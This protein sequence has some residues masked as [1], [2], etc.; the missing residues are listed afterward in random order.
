L[1][2]RDV[3]AVRAA[4]LRPIGGQGCRDREAK[5]QG[6]REEWSD[7][8]EGLL[9]AGLAG[10]CPPTG[11]SSLASEAAVTR[12]RR[13]NRSGNRS[14]EAVDSVMP[15]LLSSPPPPPDPTAK[16]S[17]RE[18]PRR[19]RRRGLC[20]GTVRLASPGKRSSGAPQPPPLALC[21]GADA[22]RLAAVT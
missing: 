13:N 21:V 22:A 9:K 2:G 17:A 4:E 20:P 5:G 7:H 14:A 11:P 15:L 1:V 10:R 6:G 16:V 18:T 8:G 19:R 3:V 12:S